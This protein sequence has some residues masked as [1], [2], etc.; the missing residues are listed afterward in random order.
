MPDASFL[1]LT[2]GPV[3]IAVNADRETKRISEVQLERKWET[4]RAVAAAR[5]E[6]RYGVALGVTVDWRPGMRVEW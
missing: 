6:V 3:S 1:M 4:R 5:S 2:V